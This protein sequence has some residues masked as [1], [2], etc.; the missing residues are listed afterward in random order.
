VVAEIGVQARCRVAHALRQGHREVDVGLFSLLKKSSDE[1]K[2]RG[3]RRGRVRISDPNVSA[4]IRNIDGSAASIGLAR[5]A[6]AASGMSN[7]E[8]AEA[9]R[10][11]AAAVPYRNQRDNG[12]DGDVMCNM[13]SMAMSLN[14]LGLG[15]DESA[16]QFENTLDARRK[17]SGLSRYDESQRETLAEKQGVDAST[18][19]TPMFADGPAA[20]AWYEKNVR[21]RLEAGQTATFG[22]ESGGF[23]HV[24]RL[25]WVEERGLKIDDPFGR[26][27]A[28]DEQGQ[29]AYS[30]LNEKKGQGGV[31]ADNHMPWDQVAKLNSNKYVQ[32]YGEKAEKVGK[33]RK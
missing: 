8:R 29:V 11:I 30:A 7:S 23:R 33:K 20:R 4:A 14:G 5:K 32:L 12:D 18:L 9:Y 26:G 6:V 3:E 17:K 25:E 21:P 2:S 10:Q 24:I 31:G 28:A 19:R 27:L 22:V 1:G 13:T 15:A 16:T